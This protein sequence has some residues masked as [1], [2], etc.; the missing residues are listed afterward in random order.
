[1]LNGGGNEDG[2]KINKSNYQNNT[3]GT[4]SF[5]VIL[6]DY[7]AVVLHDE[8]KLSSYTLF[9]CEGDCRDV[10]TKNFV[11]CIPVCFYFFTAG[12]FHPAGRFLLAASIS[13]FRTTAVNF[14]CFSSPEIRL[15]CFKSLAL[16]F[17]GYPR[18]C[19]YTKNGNN[20]GKDSTLLMF[21]S[22]LKSGW[23]CEGDCTYSYHKGFAD[24]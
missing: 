8:V 3:F 20:V 16:A 1:M 24:H 7:N 23:P 2:N 11:V 4:F 21:F 10:L 9:F 5:V 17:L 18:K 6:H 22:L 14:Y 13:Y 19:R 15:L 12:H